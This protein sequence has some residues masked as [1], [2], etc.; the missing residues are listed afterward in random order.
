MRIKIR[1]LG[2]YRSVYLVS[3]L[4]LSAVGLLPALTGEAF[5]Y[6]RVTSRSLQMTTSLPGAAATYTTTFTPASSTPIQGMIIDFCS[7][8]PI[9]GVSCTAPSSFSVG[10]SPAGTVTVTGQSGL[11]WSYASANSNRTLE[12]TSTGTES[13]T[14]T[15]VSVSLTT[16]TN[17]AAPAGTFYARVF[18]FAASANVASWE[19]DTTNGPAG[20]GSSVLNVLDA[21]GLALSTVTAISISA[22]VQETLQFCVSAA[23]FSGS[24]C[25]GATTPSIALGTGTP[26]VLDSNSVYTTPA[27]T[28]TSSN[29]NSGVVVKMSNASGC[30][31]GGL[32]SG[33]NCIPGIGA[34]TTMT[35][36]TADFGLNV[37]DSINGTGT[38]SHA[39]GYGT[40]ANNYAM[41]SGVLTPP[42]DQIEQSTAPVNGVD[43]TLTFAA[44][45]ANTTPAGIYTGNFQLVATGTF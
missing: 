10:A 41:T 16:A 2:W 18:T 39:T 31:N 44:T 12:L 21:G 25:A 8:N 35:A 20:D 5:A 17:P 11:T 33:S 19:S 15:A 9:I 22:T 36:G 29:A 34:F 1:G 6:G 3:A 7:N 45:A 42:G 13:G 24:N 27:Y 30:T 40:T 4:V 28:Q 26:K 32:K 23:T 37:A 14:P 43:N 38:M